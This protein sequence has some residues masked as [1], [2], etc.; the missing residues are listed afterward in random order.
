MAVPYHTHSF[1]IPSATKSEVEAGIRTDVAAT[2]ASLGSAASKDISYFATSEQGEAATTAVQSVNGKIGKTITLAKA[3]IGLGSVENTSDAEKPISTA[4]QAALIL[5]ANAIDLGTAASRNIEDFATADQ[6]ELASTSAQQNITLTAGNGLVGGGTLAENRTFALSSTSLTSLAKADSAVQ[7]SRKVTAGAGL[8][9]GGDF[10]ADRVIALN[11]NSLASLARADSAVQPSDLGALASKDTITTTDI[12]AAGSTD[13]YAILTRG[14]SWIKPTGVGDMLQ[15]VYDPDGTGKVLK[16][17]EA[18]KVALVAVTGLQD[19]LDDKA[20]AS[21]TDT[22][23][24]V[25][26]K[27]ETAL[28]GKAVRVDVSQP[29]TTAEQGQALSN[30]GAGVLSGFRNKIINGDFDVWQRGTSFTVSGYTADRWGVYAPPGTSFTAAR[31]VY[32]TGTW[33]LLLGRTATGTGDLQLYQRIENVRTLAGKTVTVTFNAVK[34][35]SDGGTSLPIDVSLTQVFGSGGSANVDAGVKRVTATASASKISV[36]FELPSVSDKMTGEGHN[37]SL[38]LLF[39]SSSG[40]FSGLYLSRVSLVEGDATAED[41]PSSPRHIQQELAIRQRYF[42]RVSEI[43]MQAAFQAGHANRTTIL[44]PVPMRV[45]PTT[46]Y[47]SSIGSG[48]AI[49][50]SSIADR[51]VLAAFPGADGLISAGGIKLD[52]EI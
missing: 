27:I 48:V 10:A 28:S 1:E 19:A 12:S 24:Q 30:I 52:A 44:L 33:G 21:E 51:L 37:L 2:P 50:S 42:Q 35:G 7:P 41:D 32:G 43:V 3:D 49:L 31:A 4:T 16:A 14:G 47:T 34:T 17:V 5:K 45:P 39:P 25:N 6:G 13:P 36:T 40:N 11:A 18:E 29:L 26:Q 38:V 23:E 9:G 20:D 8:T 46:T 15:A 22:K